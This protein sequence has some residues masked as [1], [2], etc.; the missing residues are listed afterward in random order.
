MTVLVARR[1]VAGDGG[2]TAAPGWLAFEGERVVATGT[3]DPP[4][5]GETVDL[6]DALLAPGFL[7][8]QVNGHG[9][10]DFAS[11]SVGEIVEAIDALAAQGCAGCLPTLVSAPL[12]HYDATC[13]RLSAAR[14]A[15]PDLVLGVHLEGPF[16]GDAPGA[17]ARDHLRAADAD[18]LD[19]LCERFPG[20]VRLVTL[21]PEADPGFEATRRLAARGIAVALGH[22]RAS[23]DDARAA[24]DAGATMVT[25]VFNGMGPLHH[26]AP[27]VAGAALDDRR[28]VPSLVADLVHVHPAVV[29]LVATVRP[30][31]VVVS[32]AVATTSAATTGDAA[33]LADGTLAGSLVTIGD[34]VGNLVHAGVT[35]GQAIRMATWNPARVLGLA[36]RGRLA[37]GCRADVLALDPET[38]SVRA[39]W[40]GGV[41][42]GS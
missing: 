41:R 39:R 42:R 16:L 13:A 5:A 38:L 4:P 32:D 3:G 28:L 37:A 23:Y 33:R 12:E 19:S 34:C 36:D 27:G 31:A 8:L 25:H 11:A 9:A 14:D 30:D 35:V 24:A 40:Q 1:V 17:H 18:W 21:A 26:R 15:R 29:R 20:L 6:G 2:V 7:E 22:T 10:V